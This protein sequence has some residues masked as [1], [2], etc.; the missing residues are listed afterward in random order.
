MSRVGAAIVV[1]MGLALFAGAV[2]AQPGDEL[3]VYV[4]TMGPGDHPFFKFG[5][6]AIWVRDKG[7]PPGT[8]GGGKVY[9]WGTFRFDSPRLIPD[10]IKGRLT[11]WLSV[12]SFERT[13]A[14]YQSENRSIEVQE[15]DLAAPE[16]LALAE[17]LEVNARPENRNYKYDYF[18]DNCSTRVRDAVNTAT[19]G[20]LRTSAQGAARPTL[21]E[22]ALRPTADLPWEYLTMY[23]ILGPA[24]DEP[25]DRWA[26]MFIPQKLARRLRAV[27]LPRLP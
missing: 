17:R 9:N 26:E 16:K 25:V 18:L 8:D 27:S 10:F 3:S 14:T 23:L 4:M 24:T 15:L 13:V 21:R 6:D 19:G 12:A 20:R 22:Q 1:G 7:A 2:R 5:H 11:Y